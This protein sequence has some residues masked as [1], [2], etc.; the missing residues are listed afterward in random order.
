M[1]SSSGVASQSEE[2]ASK[3]LFDC[4][5]AFAQTLMEIAAED[6]RVC[7]VVND[8]VSST[9]LKEFKTRF[10]ER[11]VNV[12]IAE[13]NMI[14]VGAGLA[15]GGM[16]PFVCGASCF[17]TARAMEQ[18]KVDLAYSRSNVKL[19]G[20]SSGM[21]YGPL[22]PTHHSI[23][24]V[25]WTRVIPNLQVIVPADPEETASAIRYAAGYDGPV[26]VRVSRMP[27]PEVMP[28]GYG[29][30]AG[31][32]A[33]LREGNDVT[34]LASGVMVSRALAAAASLAQRG[35]EARVLNMSSIKP[36]DEEAVMRAAR[37]TRGLVTVEEGLRAGGLG[38]AVAEMLAVRGGARLRILGI[39]DA[40]APTG[41]AE[42]L[43]EHFGLT[44]RGIE[45][46]ALEVIRESC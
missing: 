5:D 2:R 16:V 27:V 18:I 37:E 39:P 46:A 38:G 6:K 14:G 34:L 41:T 24:D 25:A 45:D 17:L 32:A 3:R 12:G 31:R 7:A 8:S 10:P 23:E 13:Q 42:F 21:A 26:F 4:R 44:A 20:M 40:F 1:V 33:V 28:E 11:F 43:L 15:N 19:C 30:S 35:V 22:G 36:L 29:F 9:K